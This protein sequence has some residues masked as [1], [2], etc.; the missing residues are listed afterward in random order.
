MLP[1]TLF[2]P[3][4]QLL[5]KWNQKINLIGKSTEREIYQRHIADSLRLLQHLHPEETIC[6]IGS[7]AGLPGIVLSIAGVKHVTLV[8]SDKRKCAFLQVASGLSPNLIR[9]IDQRVEGLQLECDR[10][11][12]RAFASVSNILALTV[13]LRARNGYL[14]LKGQHL[15]RELQEARQQW[16]FKC[17]V[18]EG[19][20]AEI[21][22]VQKDNSG[23]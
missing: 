22:D 7:G 11:V 8:E 1:L 17:R 6:D 9:L 13:G 5:L 14:L 23:S 3:Y 12:C 2:S 10:I 20:I 16:Q 15:E 21:T 4:V 19:N 18:Y